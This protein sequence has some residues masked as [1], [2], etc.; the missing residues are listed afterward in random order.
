MN[1]KCKINTVPL[2]TFSYTKLGVGCHRTVR[3]GSP[4][5]SR[6]PGTYSLQDF[7][8]IVCTESF[9]LEKGTR[10]KKNKCSTGVGEGYEFVFNDLIMLLLP[11]LTIDLQYTQWVI[12]D[13]GKVTPKIITA[14]TQHSG[15]NHKFDRVIH[16]T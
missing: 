13:N 8:A 11:G 10:G 9:I 14:A 6:D 15:S 3:I 12:D 1:I 16:I 4:T 2:C 5:R 7:N